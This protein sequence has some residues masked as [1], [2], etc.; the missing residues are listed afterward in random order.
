M[1]NKRAIFL[2]TFILIAGLLISGD[3]KEEIK[4]YVAIGD[5]LTA[6]YQNGG[7]VETFQGFSFPNI[8]ASQLGISDF[9]QPL[10]SYPGIPPIYVLGVEDGEFTVTQVSG[11]GEPKNL[12]L[13]R[14]YDNLGIPGATLYTA[15]N[16]DYTSTTNPFYQIIL[17]NMGNAIEQAIAL[18]PDLITFWLGN[19]EIL[20]AATH[21]IVIEGQTVFPPDQYAQLLAYALGLIKSNTSAKVIVFNIPDITAIP[22][23]NYVKPYIE[24]NGNKVYLIGPEGTMSD[25]WKVLLPALAYIKLGYGIPAEYGG[26]GLPLPDE[27]TLSPTEITKLNN[28]VKTYNETIKNT[29]ENYGMNLFDVNTFFSNLSQNGIYIGGVHFTSEYIT[30]GLFS[31]DGV[32]PSSIGYAILANEI[33]KFLNETYDYNIPLYSLKELIENGNSATPPSVTRPSITL[34]AIYKH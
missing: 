25:E 8:I 16:P 5:S 32:H 1:K 23:V 18:N 4:K 17:R 28:Y 2:L 15:L 9:E 21:G 26:N 19:N 33:I 30:G 13:A 7:L 11:M 20:Y 29:A 14:P 12:T 22:Y 3:Y 24:V 31:L 10:I 6:G 27:V 34:K